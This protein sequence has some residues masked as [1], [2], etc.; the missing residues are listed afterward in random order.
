MGHCANL[1][2]SPPPSPPFSYS[3]RSDNEEEEEDALM[4]ITGA[5]SPAFTG[6]VGF[7]FFGFCSDGKM[8]LPLYF[9]VLMRLPRSLFICLLSWMNFLFHSLSL[10]TSFVFVC[11]CGGV[12]SLLAWVLCL[13]H[14][15]LR[16]VSLQTK[17]INSREKLQHT[18]IHTHTHTRTHAPTHARTHAHTHLTNT[19]AYEVS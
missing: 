9:S 13:C 12:G 19:A 14:Y 17:Y 5:H 8:L 4:I 15:I 11:V 2:V 1:S 18:H 7:F 16:V 6:G 10:H 3:Y